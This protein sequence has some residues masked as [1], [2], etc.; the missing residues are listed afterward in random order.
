[1]TTRFSSPSTIEELL[2]HA[3]LVALGSPAPLPEPS[4]ALRVV[5][6]P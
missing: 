3:D 2:P 4:R 1:V 6:H 5:Q